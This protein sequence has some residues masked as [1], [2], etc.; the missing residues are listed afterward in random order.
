MTGLRAGRG[1]I[2]DADR[3]ELI[4]LLKESVEMTEKGFAVDLERRAER[5]DTLLQSIG[6][7]FLG[8][9]IQGIPEERNVVALRQ[10]G[11]DQPLPDG[12]HFHG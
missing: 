6:R 5:W 12:R 10:G 3:N 1:Y 11:T 8:E 2:T 7:V 4:V 9:R